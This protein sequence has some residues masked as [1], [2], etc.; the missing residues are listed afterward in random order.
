MLRHSICVLSVLALTGN[1]AGCDLVLIEI[2][3]LK[4]ESCS[5]AY[6]WQWLFRQNKVIASLFST[7]RLGCLAYYSLV[8]FLWLLRT[9]SLQAF[10]FFNLNPLFFSFQYWYDLKEYKIYRGQNTIYVPTSMETVRPHV[11]NG[12]VLPLGI[13]LLVND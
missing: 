4:C 11:Q 12:A 2:F 9:F 7:Q 1:E 5:Y 10:C 13:S 8:S 3:L 6:K